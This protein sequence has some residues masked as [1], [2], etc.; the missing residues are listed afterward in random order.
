MLNFII[1]WGILTVKWSICLIIVSLII[2]GLGCGGGNKTTNARLVSISDDISRTTDVGR[3]NDY[4]A[5]NDSSIIM[6]SFGKAVSKLV[7]EGITYHNVTQFTFISSRCYEYTNVE[8]TAGYP[9]L[10]IPNFRESYKLITVRRGC[11]DFGKSDSTVS[12][13]LVSFGHSSGRRL[14]ALKLRC[15]ESS[16]D[17]T[18]QDAKWMLRQ[19]EN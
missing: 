12:I 10:D 14:K 9:F 13:E 7:Y 6:F 2:S 11:L 19:C 3:V 1:I 5:D 15:G 16:F 18:D 8:Y 17:A 4:F